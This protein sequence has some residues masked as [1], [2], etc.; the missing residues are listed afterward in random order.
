[1]KNVNTSKVMTTKRR[2]HEVKSR[3]AARVNYAFIH[4]DKMK[5]TESH[6][7]RPEHRFGHGPAA[8]G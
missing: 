4:V 3:H 6:K 1:M 2:M 8:V 7:P 5:R